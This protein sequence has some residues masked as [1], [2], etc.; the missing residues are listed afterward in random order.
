MLTYALVKLVKISTLN[1]TEWQENTIVHGSLKILSSRTKLC[2]N[3]AYQDQTARLGP[4]EKEY[5]KFSPF[6]GER[7]LK[8]FL[9]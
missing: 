7:R 5:T 3:P 4:I 2:D 1:Y 8:G 9:N 6:C